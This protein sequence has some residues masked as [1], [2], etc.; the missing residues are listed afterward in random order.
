MSEMK[1]DAALAGMGGAAILLK[2][3]PRP[4]LSFASQGLVSG[5]SFL[6]A[7]AMLH[8][9]SAHDYSAY[10]LFINT[11]V[12]LSG[13]LNALLLSPLVTLSGQMSVLAREEAVRAGLWL[14]AML[15][16]VGGVALLVYWQ[17]PRVGQ[18]VMPWWLW[19]AVPVAFGLLLQRDLKR[20]I[21]LLLGEF[22][23]LLRLDA[24]Y[25][26]LTC[27]LLFA[28]WLAG[29]LSLGVA[30]LAVSVPALCALLLRLRF[31]AHDAATFIYFDAA[32]RKE[33]WACAKWALPGVAVTWL[34]SN[35]YWFYL[36]AV[37]GQTA[38]ALLAATRLFYTPVGLMI[39][40]WAGYYRPA[41]SRL[42]HAGEQ[43]AKWQLARRQM[44]WA[45]CIVLIFAVLLATMSW[46]V[47]GL[48]PRFIDS[49]LW[50]QSVGLWA[51]YFVVQWVRTIVATALLANPAGYRVVF[52]GGVGGCA[53]F[54]ALFMPLA[55]LTAQPLYCPLALIVAE[56]AI[57]GWLWKN[58]DV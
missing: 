44:A 46:S 25:C 58:R 35:G 33:I 34:F 11:F 27:A 47:P 18:Q 6:S 57:A 36:D 9:G 12:L 20:A 10:V 31:P 50:Q 38:V 8:W 13:L 7:L 52:L 14:A 3:I 4:V 41:F 54:Y 49:A 2:R 5:A 45:V 32:L 43:A 37:Q 19:L 26:A 53:L 30:V 15:A 24:T 29:S 48:V 51:G 55:A 40:G 39:Q 17:M 21:A 22:W 16:L 28:A 42:E 1:V 56:I 23:V